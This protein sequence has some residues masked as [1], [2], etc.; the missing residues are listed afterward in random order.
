MTFLDQIM[1]GRPGEAELRASF[2]SSKIGQKLNSKAAVEKDNTD[3]MW[4]AQRGPLRPGDEAIP[5]R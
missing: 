5:S 1:N 2:N 4:H 3:D